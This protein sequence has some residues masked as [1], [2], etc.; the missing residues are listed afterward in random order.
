MFVKSWCVA[1]T[2][3]LQGSAGRTPTSVLKILLVNKSFLSPYIL[4]NCFPICVSH[5]ELTVKIDDEK[6]CNRFEH[7]SDPKVP[8]LWETRIT[9]GSF[10]SIVFAV[11]GKPT[12]AL[13]ALAQTT[14]IAVGSIKKRGSHGVSINFKYNS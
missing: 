4:R 11:Y 10:I 3:T 13:K 6:D 14:P 7:A 5:S 8:P 1:T 2:L 9:I 12:Q